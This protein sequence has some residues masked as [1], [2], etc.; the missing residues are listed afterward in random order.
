MTTTPSA[1]EIAMEM[2][3]RLHA[4]RLRDAPAVLGIPNA[5]VRIAGMAEAWYHRDSS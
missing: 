1:D 4:E 2:A 3:D 5:A